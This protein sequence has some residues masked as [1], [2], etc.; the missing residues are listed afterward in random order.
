MR[1]EYVSGAL[2]ISN[3]VVLGLWAPARRKMV[4]LIEP[5]L[6]VAVFRLQPG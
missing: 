1:G 3:E 5:Q 2:H 4:A 6:R